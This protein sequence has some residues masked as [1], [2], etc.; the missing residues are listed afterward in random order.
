[1]VISESKQQT[2]FLLYIFRILARRPQSIIWAFL[3]ATKLQ[4]VGHFWPADHGVHTLGLVV[5]LISCRFYVNSFVIVTT[6]FMDQT[7]TIHIVDTSCIYAV[8]KLSFSKQYRI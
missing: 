5:Y 2:I 3:R 6:Y 7:I 8:F 1:V 4:L